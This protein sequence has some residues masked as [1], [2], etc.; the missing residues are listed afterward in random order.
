[1][2]SKTEIEGA[3][4][5]VSHKGVWIFAEQKDGNLRG[6]GLE[7]LGVG[8]RLADRLG[9]DLVAVLLGCGIEELAKDLVAY[10]ADKIIL[11]EHELLGRYTTET[12]TNVLAELVY[13]YK[14]SV[15]LMGGTLN[16]REL[17]PRLAARLSTGITADCTDFDIDKDGHLLQI[18]P[19]SKL[20]AKIKCRTKPQ[21]ATAKPNAFKRLK[22]DWSRKGTVIREEV[23]VSPNETRT[24]VIEVIKTTN[25]IYG[26]VEEADVIV[27][28]GRG[29]GS[30]ENFKL[31]HD[32]A[33]LLGATVAGTRSV[34]DRGWLPASQ[35]VGQSGKMVAPRLYVAAGISGATYHTVGMQK[36]EVIVA[37]N[38]DAKAPIFQIATYGI[39]G[40]LFE[41]LPIFMDRLKKEY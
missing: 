9:E 28:G 14:P 38:K 32:L 34:V 23:K 39:V 24:R 15:L 7:L 41:I 33:D 20:M 30:K 10:G 19:F 40:D 4:G 25:S 13:K 2:V 18:K 36:S 11:A 6:V 31:I 29:L 1:M 8:R 26:N 16:G 3:E 22:P 37:I 21:M 35:Q 27:A 12:Y 5:S 17:A